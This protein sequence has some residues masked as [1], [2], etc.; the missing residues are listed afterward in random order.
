MTPR[1]EVRGVGKRWADGSGLR[2]TS[3]AAAAGSLV[4][5]RGRSGSGKSTLL[6]IVAGLCQPDDGTILLDGVPLGRSTPRW[7]EVTFVPQTLALAVELTVRENVE[8]VAGRGQRH[9]IEALLAALDL[10]ALAGAT[11][12]AVSMGEQQ[13]CAVAR[14]LI[15]RPGVVLADEPT[16]HQDAAHAEAVLDCLRAAT[17]HGTTV[18]VASHDPAVVALATLVVDL[19]TGG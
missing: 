3:F 10:A 19:E 15:T 14:A 5:V 2:P 12:D 18:V 1:L 11:P 13:R 7:D 8:D 4:V 16:S 17:A 6:G 9:D